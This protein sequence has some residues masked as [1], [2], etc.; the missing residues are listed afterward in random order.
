MG[1]SSHTL[2]ADAP[3]S[4]AVLTGPIAASLFQW[5]GFRDHP[6]PRYWTAP[7]SVRPHLDV[8]R[9]RHWLEPVEVDGI[10]VAH[11]I[12][13]LRHLGNDTAAFPTDP[14]ISHLDRIEL[15]VEHALRNGLKL[16][17]LRRSSLWKGRT[18][19]DRMLA[20][21]LIR[22]GEEPPTESYAETRQVQCLRNWGYHCW[23]QV[24]IHEAGR[25]KHRVDL[26]VPFDQR[27]PR[28]RRPRRLV[29]SDGL[30][31]EVDSREFHQTRFEG[32]HARETTYDLLGFAWMSFTPSQ[33]E[34]HPDRVR[35]AFERRFRQ[36]Q[37]NARARTRNTQSRRIA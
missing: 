9:T 12:L 35:A 1:A 33:L 4:S 18:Q 28:R 17:D 36:A 27:S 16:E 11:P 37:L 20:A 25:V 29:P 14:S 26:V 31:L 5:D 13:V 6:W 7:A 2:H 34:Q 3:R 30:L 15:A 21:V 22:R 32:D 8:V 24:A 23:R 19:G 10:A